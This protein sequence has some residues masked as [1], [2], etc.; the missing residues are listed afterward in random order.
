VREKRLTMTLFVLAILATGCA[1]HMTIRPGRDSYYVQSSQ[2]LPAQAASGN[3]QETRLSGGGGD[4]SVSPTLKTTTSP[5]GLVL[6][7]YG[8]K[9]D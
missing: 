9:E 1:R 7:L 5:R 6:G 8:P 2:L 4:G 3:S